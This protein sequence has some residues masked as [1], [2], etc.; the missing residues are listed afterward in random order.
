M[1]R[2]VLICC[3]K[4]CLKKFT[5]KKYLNSKI[6]LKTVCLVNKIGSNLICPHCVASLLARVKNFEFSSKV[7]KNFVFFETASDLRFFQRF[8]KLKKI[9]FR[10][11]TKPT[12]AVASWI[13]GAESGIE[14]PPTT[15][16][17]PSSPKC[18]G[19]TAKPVFR[20]A[21]ES[22]HPGGYSTSKTS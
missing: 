21:S 10:K 4:F 15:H 14:P 16:A 20:R 6:F 11:Y 13:S 1:G 8:K 5:I 3:H 18:F 22:D 7:P 2:S 17:F 12:T 9:I 19:N